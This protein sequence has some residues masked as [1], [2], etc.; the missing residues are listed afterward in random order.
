M[1]SIKIENVFFNGLV[2]FPLL[3]NVRDGNG[4]TTC[5]LQFGKC[6]CFDAELTSG[7]WGL[8]WIIA[9]QAEPYSGKIFLNDREFSKKE[10]RKL[11]QCVGMDVNDYFIPRKKTIKNQI[12]KGL[13]LTKYKNASSIEEVMERFSIDKERVGRKIE[14]VGPMMF[15]ASLG[16]GYAFNKRIYCF[17]WLWQKSILS[18]KDL[19]LKEQISFLKEKGSL[20]II[21]T[22][23]SLDMKDLFDE[24][25]E[26]KHP[27]S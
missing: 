9:G 25:I 10:R 24:V 17:P 26:F 13:G 12:K 27:L 3:G 7:G 6:Y 2:Y 16:I 23:Y 21:P 20:I 22:K 19:W 8:S 5:E 14:N 15:K 11:S 1:D 4:Y 18:F